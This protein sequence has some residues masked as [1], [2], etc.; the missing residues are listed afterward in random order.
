[1]SFERQS[2]EELLCSAPLAANE[3]SVMLTGVVERSR[4]P[5]KFVLVLENGRSL[6]LDVSAVKDFR[7]LAGMIG[8]KLVE[9][10]VRREDVPKEVREEIAAGAVGERGFGQYSSVPSVDRVKPILEG[11][12]LPSQDFHT[13]AHYDRKG[14]WEEPINTGS[15]D[16][17]P[18]AYNDPGY[19]YERDMQGAL[20]VI[21]T[22][23]SVDLKHPW[24]EP[25]HTGY[26][27]HPQY[28]Y[29]GSDPYGRP[30]PVMTPFALATPHQ[31]PAEAIAAMA[32]PS[33]IGKR[34]SAEGG[35][36]PGHP[37]SDV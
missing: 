11:T 33:F 22:F 12:K 28:V 4:H 21:R 14:S 13:I 3:D 17:Q 19:G 10:E 24:E 35:T 20:R 27:D 2:F 25:P 31:A 8:Q 16:P 36:R 18:F 34:G 23:P 6:V 30:Y 1:M 5:N 15:F 7:V 37:H 9:I 29:G 26:W 32:S